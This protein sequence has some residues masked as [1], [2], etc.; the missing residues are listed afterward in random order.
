MPIFEYEP[1]SGDCD[2][3]GGRFEVFQKPHLRALHLKHCPTCGQRCH[4]V[5]STFATGKDEKGLFSDKNVGEK[6]FVKYAKVGKGEYRRVSG[7]TGPEHLSKD[8][9]DAILSKKG[10]D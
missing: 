3:C 5:V 8:K 2:Q 1:D 6:G 7:E 9:L 10:A 4:R